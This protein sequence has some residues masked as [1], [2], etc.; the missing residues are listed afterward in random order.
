L[1]K[2][3]DL[4]QLV[5]KFFL[6]CDNLNYKAEEQLRDITASL[7]EL[8]LAQNQALYLKNYLEPQLAL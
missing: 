2:D 6:Q 4:A 3:E 1:Q 8:T 7:K 5:F